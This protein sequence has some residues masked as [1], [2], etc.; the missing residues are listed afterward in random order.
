MCGIVTGIQEAFTDSWFLVLS[1]FPD[2]VRKKLISHRIERFKVLSVSAREVAAYAT[3]FDAG[4]LLRKDNIINEVACPLKWLEYWRCGVPI[5]T[6]KAVE[7]IN[8]AA[9]LSDNCII[10]LEHRSE[11]IATIVKYLAQ[12]RDSQD[13]VRAR[14]RLCVDKNWTWS[15]WQNIFERIFDT[16]SL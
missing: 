1:P 4:F 6:T 14:L 11:A 15:K 2:E 9:C 16:L 13:S 5:I 7:I 3:A 12:R 8:S 10:D